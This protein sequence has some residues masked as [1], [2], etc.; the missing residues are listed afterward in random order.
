MKSHSSQ[1][2]SVPTLIP[3]KDLTTG[4]ISFVEELPLKI[5]NS[6]TAQSIINEVE[7]VVKGIPRTP[8]ITTTNSP[9]NKDDVAGYDYDPYGVSDTGGDNQYA[10]IH[11]PKIPFHNYR[12]IHVTLDAFFKGY[13]STRPLPTVPPLWGDVQ[14][15]WNFGVFVG[16]GL[17][18]FIRV[19]GGIIIA[20]ITVYAASKGIVA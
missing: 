19:F 6:E 2:D 16:Y 20:G 4:A 15:Y 14:H 8:V 9:D 3:K 18:E 12:Q 11:T 13:N 1:R 10:D 17:Y 5:V 7:K